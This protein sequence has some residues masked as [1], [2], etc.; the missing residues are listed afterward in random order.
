MIT[1]TQP[2]FSIPSNKTNQSKNKLYTIKAIFWLVAIIF[3][4][5]QAW[6]NRYSI[7]SEDGISYLD[8]AD[9][10]LRGDWNLAINPH[11]SPLYSWILGLALFILKPS[12]YWEFPVVKLVNFIVYLFTIFCFDFF[13]RNF[14]FDYNQ[15]TLASNKYLKVPNWVLLVLGYILFLWSS[16]K[17]IGVFCDSPDMLTAA[18]IY[19]AAGIVLLIKTSS[20]TWFNFIMLGIVLGLG[21]L[22]KSVVFPVAFVFLGVA[23]FAVGNLRKGVSRTIAALLVFT[24]IVAPFITAISTAKG[25]L[26]I[27]EA[28]KLSYAWYISPRVSDHHW[29]G[30]PPGS[31]NPEHPTRQI[32]TK[33]AAFEFGNPINSTYPVWYN[34]PYWNKGLK[35]T[36]NLNKQVRSIGKNLFFYTKKFLGTLVFGYLILVCISGTFRLSLKN[37]ATRWYL[38]L[39]AIAGLGIF[40]VTTDMQFLILPMHISTRYIAPFIVLLF[41]AVYSSV[42]LLNSKTAKR[43]LAGILFATL[44][45]SVTQLGLQASLDLTIALKNPQHTYWKIA[46]NLQQYG[47]KPGDKVANLGMAD[48]YWARLARVKVVAEIPEVLD[49]WAADAQSKA[50]VLE[51]VAKTGAKVIV[52]KTDVKLPSSTYP[53]SWLRLGNTDS[54]AYFFRG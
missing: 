2:V 8:I 9:A 12:P 28:G 11:W 53:A 31:G 41:A 6:A 10:Y 34:P 5:V 32:F 27:G 45:I 33:P 20:P 24:V 37:L 54:Y 14:I 46:D 18:F 38:L 49:F 1:K 15:K 25:H 47:I 3:G 21:Y 35:S 16:L 36:F 13:L 23:M 7:S 30:E 42:L 39:P 17:F 52:Q 50:N 19:L 51:A 29:Q 48:Y 26:T 44:L 43:W 22:S 40:A 4:A